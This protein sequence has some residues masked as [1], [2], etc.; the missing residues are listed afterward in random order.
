M[1]AIRALVLARAFIWEAQIKA[2]VYC[3]L[4]YYPTADELQKR[5]RVVGLD[6]GVDMLFL[7]DFKIATS[8]PIDQSPLDKPIKGR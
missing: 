2:A 5:C 4:G 6:D 1:D 3:A 8:R 7:D